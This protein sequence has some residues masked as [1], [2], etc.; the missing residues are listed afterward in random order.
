ME[1]SEALDFLYLS[2]DGSL[3]AQQQMLLDAH[4]RTCFACANTLSRAQRFQ[5]I[6]VQV[7]QLSVPRGLEDRIIESVFAASGM[8]NKREETFRTVVDSFTNWRSFGLAFGTAAAALALILIS[9][10]VMQQAAMNHQT[11]ERTLTAAVD[12][13]LQIQPAAGQP[14]QAGSNVAIAP[15]E[16]LTSGDARP[17]TVALASGLAITLSGGTQV[18]VGT[19]KVDQQTGDPDVIALRVDHGTV[20]VRENLSRGGSAV[21]VATDQATVVPT[22]T[23]F[24]VSANPGVTQVAVGEGSV[25]VYLPGETFNVTAGSEARITKDKHTVGKIKPTERISH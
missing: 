22:G 24:T 15:G 11:P 14:E 23:I 12:G 8:T 25:E 4:R 6:L 18:R 20:G 19:V 16:T 13:T 9:R 17:A 21:H 1:C 5:Q 2:F 7:P 3:T 10:N